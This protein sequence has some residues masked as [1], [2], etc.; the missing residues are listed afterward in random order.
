MRPPAGVAQF[1]KPDLAAF[2]SNF[3]TPKVEQASLNLE[4]EVAHRLAVGASYM[5]VHG[6]NL[7]RARDVNLPPPVNVT[8]PVYDS[9]GA[10]FLGTYYNVASFSTWQ[11]TP[12]LTCAFPPC[13]NSPS[14]PISQLGAA[15]VFE[16]A[17]SSV[18][19]GATLSIRRRM[20][21]GLYFM[22]S[23]TF[24]HAIDDGQDALVAG[25]PATVQNSYAPSS[26]RGSSVTDQRQRLAFSWVVAPRPFHRGH[27]W[28]GTVFNNWKM[29]G[30]A[31]YGSGRPVNAT[32]A[33]DANQ[34]GNST[35]DRLPGA[36][37]NSFIGPDYATT[38]IRLTRRIYAGDRL[39]MELVGESFNLLNRDNRRVLIT[40]DG[41][42]SNSASFV[43]KSKRIG[44][45][46][47]PAQYRVPGN[48]LRATSAYAPRQMQLALK[49]IF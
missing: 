13:I 12:S 46:R 36:R 22:L 16:S 41:F 17:A 42:Q 23:Y 15:D 39:K 30:I 37:R 20:T 1:L 6:E 3:Q 10:N 48:F 28:L 19:N 29:A 45:N 26:E 31:T 7:I 18:Y 11:L 43:Q 49:V 14:R 5:Y 33:G 2:A 25:R 9:S 4:R 38:D 8:Y 40:E 35:N 34:D 21:G 44:I 24:A 27:E 32:V 47:F